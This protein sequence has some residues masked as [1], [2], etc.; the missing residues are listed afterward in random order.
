MIP[1]LDDEE[2]MGI[3]TAAAVG[4]VA[5]LTGGA[6]MILARKLEARGL[7]GERDPGEPEW[8]VSCALRP[9]AGT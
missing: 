3:G 7:L 4:A 9:G 8:N 2:E 1:M 5:G 6:A